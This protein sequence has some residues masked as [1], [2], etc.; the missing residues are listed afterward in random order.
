MPVTDT[1]PAL[2]S[3]GRDHVLFT[4]RAPGPAH[5]TCPV[6]VWSMRF[7]YAEIHGAPGAGIQGSS[8]VSL[9]RGIQVEI[10]KVR[11]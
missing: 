3:G 11:L 2:S 6:R 7:A 5:R 10:R 8:R 1:R 9:F 4:H